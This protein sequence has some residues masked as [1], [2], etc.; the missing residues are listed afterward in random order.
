MAVEAR[1]YGPVGWEPFEEIV[2]GRIRSDS[3]T[4]KLW[5]VHR[6][7]PGGGWECLD[8]RYRDPAKFFERTYF[9]SGLSEVL[10]GAVRRLV[11]GGGDAV[12][13]LHTGFG[14]GKSHTLVAIYHIARNP[15]RSLDSVKL[16]R[17]L[18]E[19][20]LRLPQDLRVAVSVFD[21]AALDPVSL[22]RRYGAPN[23]WVF[24]MRELAEAIGD[25][26]LAREV[27]EYRDAVPGHDELSRL[28]S[29]IESRGFKPVVLIDE[30][31]VYLRNL[32]STG[33]EKEASALRVFIHNLAVAASNARHTLVVIATPQQYE[34]SSGVEALL[35][36]VQRV[37]VT[38]S[39]VGPSDAAEIL[40]S[41][42]IREVDADAAERAAWRYM[43]EY[44]SRRERYPGELVR[45]EYKDELRRSYPFHP[46]LV[47]E[48]YENV[49][50]TP[51]FQ[52]TR[53]VLRIAA[54]TLHYRVKS[55]EQGVTRDFV[56]LGDVDVTRHE[57]RDLLKVDNPQLRRLLEAVSYDVEVVKDLDEERV[58]RGLGRVASMVYSAI[59]LRSISGRYMRESEVMAAAV[60]PL[61]G[62][63]VELV[64]S[65]LEQ[66][67]RETAHLH[68][69]VLETGET[70]YI[71]KTKANVYM[72]VAR[73][74]RELLNAKRELLREE[75]RERLKRLASSTE[76][77]LVVWPIHPGEVEDSP[78][79]KVVLLDPE[80]E[81]VVSGDER[82]L[83]RLMS[84]FIIYRQRGD[85]E[86]RRH[87]N[88]MVFLVP[89]VEAY[90][91]VLR[92]LARLKAIEE[93]EAEKD[94]YGLQRDDLEGLASE[95]EKLERELESELQQLYI[96]VYYPVRALVGSDF[97]FA[98]ETLRPGAIKRGR[99]WGAVSE[100]LEAAGKLVRRSL[101]PSYVMRLVETLSSSLGRPVSL[102]DVIESLTGDV[103]KPMVLRAREAVSEALA[104]L[105]EDGYLVAVSASEDSA[106]CLGKI[107]KVEGYLF[108]PCNLEEARRYCLVTKNEEGL[109]ICRPKPPVDCVEP[110]WDE[111]SR[112]WRC[113]RR[114]ESRGAEAEA[115]PPQFS[116]PA[117]RE[118]QERGRRRIVIDEEVELHELR[119]LLERKI[120]G[121]TNA[122]LMNADLEVEAELTVER[123]RPLTNLLALALAEIYKRTLKSY[124]VNARLVIEV[125]GGQLRG[126]VDLT[127]TDIERMKSI[128]P[129]LAQLLASNS[130]ETRILV[131]ASIEYNGGNRLAFSD[132]MDA[133][134]GR[135]RLERAGGVKV[136]RLYALIE[137]PAVS[138]T[139]GG[140]AKP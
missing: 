128:A 50:Q 38:T 121:Y 55:P 93:I 96:E 15:S 29:A 27:D 47:R 135:F 23:P 25:G 105:V 82:R 126:T 58:R 48:L 21:G 7:C 5:T 36:D 117:V 131:Q 71:V 64:S 12:Y 127:F 3:F 86:F 45:D 89:N 34:E 125:G 60:T 110:V 1:K 83:K 46:L 42:L 65:V 56:L 123:A 81:D 68:K 90:R 31:A 85:S 6:G 62:V 30:L 57:I 87:R 20:G 74:A 98:R 8:E 79:L 119:E 51:G 77:R 14:G 132:F 130:R 133:F 109:T 111:D 139:D 9:S 26:G 114:A 35:S 37:A 84:R 53:D 129:G 33:R 52:G 88:T 49:A 44:L 140:A 134:V 138:K 118:S 4:V 32:L 104:R 108:V 66:L 101:T 13:L 72:I 59:L 106:V 94:R 112:S 100:V 17:F 28:F 116:V 41:A 97:D 80:S 92:G 11:E 113:E 76:A 95:R 67:A 103:E 18:E 19:R 124:V 73:K 102:S 39:I 63:N 70:A 2:E 122:F 40:K 137:E 99:L 75:L 61:R 78:R 54:W 91:R 24:I 107:G 136:K 115:T 69:R 43:K 10:A 22:R 16:R 120:G